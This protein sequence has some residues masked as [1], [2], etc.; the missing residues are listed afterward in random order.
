MHKV[1]RPVVLLMLFF[2]G[3]ANVGAVIGNDH[4]KFGPFDIDVDLDQF[5][6]HK[7]HHQTRKPVASLTTLKSALS[8]RRAFTQKP[9]VITQQH[10]V[11]TQRS[12]TVTHKPTASSDLTCY[13][14][15]G[16]TPLLRS[17]NVINSDHFYTTNIIVQQEAIRNGYSV[18]TQMGF[19]GTTL[20]P[21]CTGLLPLYQ[22][23]SESAQDH[24]Y[25]S[26]H[27]EMQSAL[28]LRYVLE[29]TLGYCMT[30]AGCGLVPL[31]RFYSPGSGDHFYTN[32]GEE[33]R[34]LE[35]ACAQQ[36]NTTC[37]YEGIQCYVWQS[38]NIS[39]C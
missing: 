10:P 1:G 17:W 36:Q 25:T 35:V 34:R 39:Q 29:G 28:K 32:S 5:R 6:H 4:F 2:H 13:N 8:T 12:P 23:W 30:Q 11:T 20:S 18:E 26:A 37:R 7:H 15:V 9:T 33:K 27:S 21:Q 31:Y 3:W 19:V 38:D 22:M 14:T 24:F 16:L